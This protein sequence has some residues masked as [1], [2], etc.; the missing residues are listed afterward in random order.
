MEKAK[1][2]SFTDLVAWQK[3]HALALSVYKITRDFPSNEQFGL[4]SQIRRAAVSA[5]PNI[6]E[7]FGRGSYVDKNRFYQMSR[8]SL[9]E[10]QSQ[11]LIARDIDYLEQGEFGRIAEETVVTMKL[12]N[13]LIKSS[14]DR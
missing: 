9:T 5:V 13:G 14:K 2:K 6:A 8:G 7:G 3:A 10:L 1:I 4:T 12:I 11:L